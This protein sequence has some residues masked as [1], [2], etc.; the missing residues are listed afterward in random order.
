M[1]SRATRLSLIAIAVGM[2]ALSD[3]VAFLTRLPQLDIYF[4]VL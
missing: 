3:R 4:R 1:R 2:T